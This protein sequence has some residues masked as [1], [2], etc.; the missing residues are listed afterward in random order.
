[1]WGACTGKTSGNASELQKWQWMRYR[2][3]KGCFATQQQAYWCELSKGN[4]KR[5]VRKSLGRT[6][7]KEAKIMGKTLKR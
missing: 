3:R 5:R 4:V 6:I 7:H 2:L 1:M